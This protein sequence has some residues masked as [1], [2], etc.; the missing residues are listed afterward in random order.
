MVAYD[1]ISQKNEVENSLVIAEI[2]EAV[3]YFP[4]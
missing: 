1:S 2:S 4:E 3:V